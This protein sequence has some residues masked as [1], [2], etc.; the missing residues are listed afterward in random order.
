MT[1]V[2]IGELE[3]GQDYYFLCKT[4]QTLEFDPCSGGTVPLQGLKNYFPWSSVLN[5]KKGDA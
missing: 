4:R 2:L 1:S 5:V 3:D